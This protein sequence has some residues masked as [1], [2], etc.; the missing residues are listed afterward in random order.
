MQFYDKRQVYDED[1]DPMIKEIE[2]ICR[3]H[4]IQWTSC[5]QFAAMEQGECCKVNGRHINDKDFPA[6]LRLHMAHIILN[7]PEPVLIEM[8]KRIG[9]LKKT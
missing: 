7:A 1:I 9:A 5:F 3:Q 4:S 2:R 8:S 6:G